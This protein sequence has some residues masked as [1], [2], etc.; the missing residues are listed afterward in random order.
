[1]APTAFV[2]PR[3]DHC[4]HVLSRPFL[5]NYLHYARITAGFFFLSFDARR[6]QAQGTD[7]VVVRADDAG[8][9]VS[10]ASIHDSPREVTDAASLL[11]P[12]PGVHVRRLGG[13]DALSTLSIRG[14]SSSQVA[15][16]LAGIPL[17]SGADPSFNLASMPLWPDAKARVYR[18]FAPATLG[19]GSLGGTLVFDP[20]SGFSGA[21]RSGGN[22]AQ[23]TEI[24]TAAGSFGSLRLRLGQMFSAQNGVRVASAI[25]ASRADNDFDV[26]DRKATLLENREVY[27]ARKNAGHADASAIA[28]ATVPLSLVGAG[29]GAVTV[30][31]LLQA[32]RQQLAGTVTDPTPFASITTTRALG[33]VDVTWPAAGGT[34]GIRSWARHESLALRDNP[35]TARGLSPTFTQDAIVA[36]GMSAGWKSPSSQSWKVDARTDLSTEHFVPGPWRGAAA[37]PQARRSALGLAL[38]SEWRVSRAT[39]L[40]ASARADAWLDRSLGRDAATI[41]NRDSFATTPIELRP[42]GNLGIQTQLADLIFATHAGI[43]SRPPSFVE[44]YG[45]G[46]AFVGEESLRPETAGTLDGGIRTEGDLKSVHYAL[47]IA[48]FGTWAR[49]LIVFVPQGAYGR[50][51][52][53][54]IGRSRLV[55]IESD[56]RIKAFSFDLRLSHTALTTTNLSECRFEANTCVH[57]PLPGRPEHDVV[58]DLGFT[59]GQLFLRYGMDAVTGI[60]ADITGSQAY[61]V[62]D[63]VLHSAGVRYNFLAVPGLSVS[64]DVRNLFDL[65]TAQ[66]LNVFG[67]RDR[68]PLGDA[69]DYPLPGRRILLSVRYVLERDSSMRENDESRMGSR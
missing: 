46:G 16:F 8:R 59:W 66:Y 32:R 45:N 67:G 51:K 61:R 13:E 48:A 39:S 28:T 17:T 3:Q 9:F 47:N 60:S 56:M 21:G 43:L 2:R 19:R 52:A 27:Y 58:A 15:V 49:D 4:C 29:L 6:A 50:A 68:Y 1:M 42:T 44:R 14:T 36:G 31:T 37:P 62:P 25:S 69:F 35:E 57:P 55:G 64:L 34:F 41:A 26:L 12:L 7:Q 23:R 53:T 24:W 10:R 54:N 40:A 18:S 20:P 11:E 38:D 5:S 22:G 33:G 63:R 30:T 65:K